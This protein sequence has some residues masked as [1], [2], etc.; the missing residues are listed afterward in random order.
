MGRSF[1]NGEVAIE[2]LA[3]KLGKVLTPGWPMPNLKIATIFGSMELNGDHKVGTN[4]AFSGAKAAE[5]DSEIDKNLFNR[6]TLDNQVNA[7]INDN[8]ASINSKSLFVIMIGAN[9]IIFAKDEINITNAL[10]KINDALN[11][12]YHNEARNFIVFNVPDI[13][14]TPL[15]SQKS[16]S[17]QEFT[18]NLT[19]QFNSGLQNIIN[20]FMETQSGS[21]VIPV[22]INKIFNNLLNEAV[23]NGIDT[24][25]PCISNI[26]N[27]QLES[28]YNPLNNFMSTFKNGILPFKYLTNN[29]NVTCNANTIDNYFFMDYIHPTKN[30]HEKIAAIVYKQLSDSI[31][32]LNI[33]KPD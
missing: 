8:R 26:S 21:R 19:N 2:I 12:L 5:G 20:N 25:N 24:Q 17:E 14:K 32:P 1:S 29:N 13:S 33:I 23:R 15:W 27:L 11:N 4:Y 28:N 16:Q 7:L 3:R 22:D 9:D 30:L 18:K 6:F 10:N 31:Q